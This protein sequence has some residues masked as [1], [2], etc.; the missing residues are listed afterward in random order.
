MPLT[1]PGSE[2]E[3][4]VVNNVRSPLFFKAF[5]EKDKKQLMIK[6]NLFR[7][8]RYLKRRLDA[9]KNA[10]M[11][12]NSRAERTISECST[13]TVSNTSTASVSTEEPG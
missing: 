12:R 8:Q 6:E 5:E 11:Y 10:K 9:L 7:E 3:N 13:G 2:S 4:I 1:R